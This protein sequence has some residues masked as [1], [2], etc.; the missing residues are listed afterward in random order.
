ME[1]TRIFLVFLILSVSD[2][3]FVL[4]G[5]SPVTCSTEGVECDNIGDNL[6]D[7]VTHV[8]TLEEC[9]QM[10]LD[11]N[12]CNFI[13]YFNHSDARV[14][15]L[16]QMFRTCDHI[17][18]T[19]NCVSENMACSKCGLALD[20]EEHTSLMLTHTG[21]TQSVT[22][23]GW[24]LCDL[25]LLLVGGGGNFGSYGGGGSGYLEYSHHQVSAGSV[26][27]AQVGGQRQ[28]S[29]VTTS[30]DTLTALPGYDG[31][32]ADGGDGYCGGGGGGY[33]GGAGGTNGG[34]GYRDGGA[35]GIGIGGPGSRWDVSSFTFNAWKLGAGAGGEVYHQQPY[36]YGGGGGG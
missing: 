27:T 15:N 32:G 28:S 5:D 1:C 7:A 2:G 23:T 24:G 19:S 34:D 30:G 13:S 8:P 11:D 25:T 29:S 31:Q 9:R 33:Y 21:Q 22:L 36:G 35:D 4:V 3:H 17:T 20:G 10:C 12:N 18:N 16:C 26:L 14:P 6:I